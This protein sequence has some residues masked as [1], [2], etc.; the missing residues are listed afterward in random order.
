MEGAMILSTGVIIIF[1]AVIIWKVIDIAD[2][3]ESMKKSMES[4]D[5]TMKFMYQLPWVQRNSKS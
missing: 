4:I 5:R 1:L 2:D 3:T